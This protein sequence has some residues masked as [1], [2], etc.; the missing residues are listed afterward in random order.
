M[1]KLTISDAALTRFPLFSAA[2]FACDGLP[3]SSPDEAIATADAAAMA[4]LSDIDPD[5]VAGHPRIAAWRETYRAMGLKPSDQ[6]S[7][8]EQLVRRGLKGSL[9]LTDVWAAE[10]YNR[11]SVAY[12]APMG[13]YDLDS[14]PGDAIEIREAAPSDSFAPLGGS[15]KGFALE[16]RI[17]VYAIG[18]EVLCWA[19]NHRDAAPTALTPAT[20]RAVFISEAT[21]AA[22]AEASVAALEALAGSLKAAGANVGP[23]GVATKGARSVEL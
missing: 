4:Q 12:L 19:L 5:A 21:D 18:N 16:P 20:K 15:D 17:L 2:A 22:G 1:V 23:I 14:L 11:W 6:R 10:A 3:D 13:G 9:S 8:I 7:S